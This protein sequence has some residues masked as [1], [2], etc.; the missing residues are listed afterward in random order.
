MNDRTA[1]HAYKSSCSDFARFYWIE[2][3]KIASTFP[4]CRVLCSSEKQVEVISRGR[5]SRCTSPGMHVCDR[6]RRK[7]KLCCLPVTFILWKL[8]PAKTIVFR[9]KGFTLVLSCQ[10]WDSWSQKKE[11]FETFLARLGQFLGLEKAGCNAKSSQEISHFVLRLSG[12]GRS[13]AG[14][15]R[16]IHFV[17][18]GVAIMSASLIKCTVTVLFACIV[19]LLWITEYARKNI[20]TAGVLGELLVNS[21]EQQVA[22]PMKKRINGGAWTSWAK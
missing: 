19:H 9:N 22:Y 3:S 5:K 1:I 8:K 10:T 12:F 2:S 20:R 4:C 7:R 16:P 17:A 11:L 21:C 14:S 6:R 13:G 15:R 18:S